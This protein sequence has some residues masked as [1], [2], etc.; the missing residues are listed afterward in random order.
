MTV[1]FRLANRE[2][3]LYMFASRGEAISSGPHQ[4]TSGMS[5]DFNIR[6]IDRPLEVLR[7]KTGQDAR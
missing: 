4:Y 1:F 2:S 3:I 7:W 5:I 6:Q